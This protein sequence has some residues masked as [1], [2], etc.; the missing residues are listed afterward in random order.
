MITIVFAGT[1][2]F[3]CPALET[4]IQHPKFD[5]RAVY[6]QPD[7]PSGR[8]RQLKASPVKTLALAHH[9]PVLQPM[10]FKSDEAC[11]ELMNLEPD[12]LIVAAY[13]L[14]LSQI[15]L[16][17]PKLGCINIHASLL[18]KW[19]GAAPIQ[20]S[21]LNGD[22]KTGITIMEMALGLDTGPILHHKSCTI[23]TKDTSP[24][25]H[26]KLSILGAEALLETLLD[27]ENKA[28]NKKAQ[29]D[30]D[31]SYAHKITKEEGQI[32]WQQSAETIERQ[33]RAL[34]PWPST[35]TQIQ[36]VILKV[37]Q[38]SIVPS[39]D[40]N[41][42]PGYITHC[43][44]QGLCVATGVTQKGHFDLLIEL[45]QLPNKQATSPQAIL[46][47]HPNFFSIGQTMG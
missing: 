4:L 23:T 18:P 8:N 34:T 10:N 39:H 27:L 42:L 32:D 2:E 36:D 35:Y 11:Q 45:C 12:L 33:I 14:I 28:N 40:V 21:I 24:T 43:S 6:T 16:D 30:H 15:V 37:H 31:A 26:N 5:V 19:R 46:C 1:P 3:A 9:I 13:G 25:L 47:G 44:E 38:A 22:Q 29:N 7:R 17:I 20:R 41:A